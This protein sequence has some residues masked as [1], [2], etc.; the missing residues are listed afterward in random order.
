MAYNLFV[1]E[2]YLINGVEN[3]MQG[4]VRA[5]L[6]DPRE[7]IF[8]ARFALASKAASKRRAE[9][10]SNGEHMP[11]FL[12][13]SITSN[14][15]LHCA[16]CFA[17]EV[18]SCSDE[19]A[20]SQLSADDW[21]KVF[22]E[23]KEL[24]IS[25]IVLVGGEPLIRKD[26]L[27]IAAN[28]S[29]ILF[30][31]FTNGTLMNDS[32][33]QLFDKARNLIPVFSIEGEGMETDRRR[34]SGIYQYLISKMDTLKKDHIP[35]GAS[36]TVTTFNLYEVTSDKFISVLQERGCKVVFFVEYVPAAH[37]SQD[38]APQ[39]AE[40]LVL[41]TSVKK[42]REAYPEMLFISF[43]GDEKKSGGCLAAGRGFFHINS[44]G[45]AEPCPLSP[46]SDINVKETSVREA[47]HSKLFTALRDGG[48]LMEDHAGGCVLFERKNQVEQLL[49][50]E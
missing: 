32:Y 7:S 48:V 38:L 39:D 36:I 6:K 18:N 2:E 42:L 35:F 5:T 13:A 44:H 43:P 26:V 9:L 11:V 45:G 14:C 17:R 49:N 25:F 20:T 22:M 23:A 50:D 34:G 31:V 12:I 28:I 37:G 8:M 19:K 16:G 40:R 15:N 41:D 47:L 3:I 27:Q 1:L 29:D 33:I 30:P 46:Y 24:G 4:A 21:K 10:E